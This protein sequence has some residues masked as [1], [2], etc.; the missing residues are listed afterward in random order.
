MKFNLSLKYWLCHKSRAFS[1][2]FAV[3]TAMAALTCTTFLVRG[4][5]VAHLEGLLDG[6]GLHDFTLADVAPETVEKYYN[7]ERVDSA[8]VIYR[9]GKIIVSEESEYFFGAITEECEPIFRFPFEDGDYPRKSGEIAL[10]RTVL[11]SFA[12]PARVGITINLDLY[13]LEDNFIES[14][15]FV[16]SGVLA[17]QSEYFNEPIQRVDSRRTKDFKY[18]DYYPPMVFLYRDDLPENPKCDLLICSYKS[19]NYNSLQNEFDDSNAEYYLNN[20][21]NISS[22]MQ[23]D[24]SL[25]DGAD[26][27][28]YNMLKYAGRD[29]YTRTLIPVFTAVTIVVAFASIFSVISSSL[30]ERRRQIAMLRCI[31]MTKTKALFML[32]LETLIIVVIGLAAGFILGTGAYLATV[33]IQKYILGMRTY[34]AFSVHPIVAAVTASPYVL[35]IL[36]CFICGF[37]AIIIPTLIELHRSPVEGL[38]E[39]TV[40]KATSVFQFNSKSLLLGKISGGFLKNIPYYIIVIAV[41]WTGVFG[42]TYF[43]SKSESDTEWLNEK[44]NTELMGMDY[45]A[46]RKEFYGLGNAQL[47]RHFLGITPE[48]AE[49]I[50][51]NSETEKVF[52]AMEIP[53]TKVIFKR[54][55]L[56]EEQEK[57]ISRANTARSIFSGMDELFYKTLAFQG[58][59][60]D[61]ILYNIPTIAIPSELFEELSDSLTAGEINAEKLR[62]G[63]EILVVR[64]D[65]AVLFALGDNVSMTDV[66]MDDEAAEEYDFKLGGVPDGAEPNFEFKYT[67]EENGLSQPG[68]AFGKRRDY[69]VKIGGVVKFTDDTLANFFK[70]RYLSGDAG[71]TFICDENAV[72]KWGLPDKNYTK[73]GVQLK[74]NYDADA[75]ETTWYET[76]RNSGG[77]SGNSIAEIYRKLHNKENSN[78]SIFMAILITIII[79]GLVGIVNSA[80]LR[81]RN[82]LRS[83]STA[84]ALGL[85]KR[86]LSGIVMRKGIICA[87][88]GAVTSFVP[89]TVF[90]AFRKAAE[91]YMMNGGGMVLS[92]EKGVKLLAWQ[93]RFP[94][95]LKLWEQ[96]LY[97]IIPLVLAAVCAVILISNIIPT[98]WI[99]NKNITDALRSNEF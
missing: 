42:C 34:L 63:E 28:L 74:M 18:V 54:G 77:V 49:K 76:V 14:R 84:R 87:I 20:K 47:N 62:S 13:D 48:Y 68:Y 52:K 39:K 11:E 44:L 72:S 12:Y 7:D 31:G 57:T 22:S 55:T 15:E 41:V 89:I 59:A 71:F 69:N 1:I 53:S 51:N 94:Y 96:P 65:D 29:E 61:E 50:E 99:A 5:S 33:F 58:Y 95:Y 32:I 82:G 24:F 17:D 73:L 3:A 4:I 70:T 35:P 45:Y 91:N 79:L 97:F 86:G 30:A 92:D 93:N 75:F 78:M 85:S 19:E 36:S 9:S 38:Q 88:I 56:N 6:S 64:P 23:L 83:Y 10:P 90:E 25:T 40:E 67:D 98:R 2:I 8:G 60:E 37:S 81:V 27:E 26:E 46:A 16:V 80:N 66:V 21:N 43:K